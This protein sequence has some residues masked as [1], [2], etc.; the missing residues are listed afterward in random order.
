MLTIEDLKDRYRVKSRKTVMRWVADELLPPPLRIGGVLRWREQDLD[1]FDEYQLACQAYRNQTGRDP[2]AAD[3]PI[4]PP[5]FSHGIPFNDP[6]QAN[7]RIAERQVL[8]RR[9][10]RN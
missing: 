7:A 10:V 5:V 9:A 6:R 4:N 1:A 2:Y 8:R 3:S